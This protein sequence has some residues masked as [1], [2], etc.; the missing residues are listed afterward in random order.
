MIELS[1]YYVVWAHQGGFCMFPLASPDQEQGSLTHVWA[2]LSSDL[3]TRLIGLLA[4]LALNMVVACSV[5]QCARKEARD[6]D[7]T[8]DAQNP[9]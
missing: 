9:S 2:D 8:A 4:Q 6:V 1:V 3:Q 5:S 7:P